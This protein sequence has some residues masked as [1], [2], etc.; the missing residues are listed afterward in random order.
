MLNPWEVYDDPPVLWAWE[1]PAD[2]PLDVLRAWH[3][4]VL[5][6][7]ARHRVFEVRTIPAIDYLR[8]RDGFIA[9]FLGRH[10][11]RLP[12]ALP[13]P[14]VVPE[15]IFNDGLDV[16]ASTLLA[17]DDTDGQV[18]EVDATSMSQLA[19]AP[20]VHPRRGRTALAPLTLSGR[21][22]FAE[23]QV[24]EGPM[25]GEIALRS[26]IWLPW[27]LAPVHVFRADDYLPNHR[28]AARHTPRLNQFLS[29]VAAATVAAGGR[30]LGAEVHPAFAFEIHD[31]GVDLEVPHPFDVYWDAP[32]A[33]GVVAAVRAGLD[34]FTAHPVRPR[35]GVVRL[36]LGTE[37]ALADAT[38]DQLLSALAA[39]PELGAYD[40]SSPEAVTKIQVTNRAGVHLLGRYLLHEARRR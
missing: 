8:E 29:E 30:W 36:A 6:S 25:Q 3:R 10:P 32:A 19:G 2:Q 7:G 11:E 27:T 23:D 26:S 22:D 39:A 35:H 12:R 38:A 5:T 16:E 37:D 34:W 15:V 20:S 24:S 4:E 31:H 14:F 28:L 21:R 40:W 9:D 33:M 1:F 18:R 17:F 13:Y